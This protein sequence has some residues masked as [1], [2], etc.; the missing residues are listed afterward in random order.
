MRGHV[1]AALG[2]P[3]LLAA[4][5]A[6]AGFPPAS[7]AR[8]LPPSP[9]APTPDDDDEDERPKGP[10]LAPGKE[11][12]LALTLSRGEARDTRAARLVA[13]DVPEGT[14]PSPFLAPGP[15]RAVWEGDLG[16]PF[17]G[18]YTF[19]AAGRGTIRVEINGKV[20]LEGS[21][22]DLGKLEGKAAKLRK[23]ANK[24]VVTYEAPTSG[25]AA[26][27]LSWSCED[28]AREPIGPVS[29]ARDVAIPAL[30][31][32]T[33]LREG[34]ALLADLRCLHC[35]APPGPIEGP[36]RMPELATDAPSLVDVGARLKAD[37]IARW[38]ADP[39]SLRPGATMPKVL[40]GPAAP[41]QARDVAAYLASLGAPAKADAPSPAPEAVTAGGRLF[42]NL[43]C[44]GCHMLP[45][46]DD[47]SSDPKRI[48]LRAVGAKW[49]PS[50]LVAFL[51]QPDRHYAW[52][53]MPN[54]H[55]SADEAGK[56]AAYVA[57]P[58]A[59]DLGEPAGSAAKA[60]PARG[61]ALVASAG[62]VNCHALPA[63]PTTAKGPSFASIGPEGWSRGCLAP[64]DGLDGKAPDFGLGEA[65]ARAL[66]ALAA[67]GLDSLTRDAQPE[68]A[69][70]QVKSLRCIACHKRDGYDDAWTDLKVETD[71]LLVGAPTEERDPD[72]LPYPADQVR[73]SLTWIGEKLK[74]EWASAFIAGKVPYKPRP[75]LRAR[76]P[77][78]AVR[79]DGL[80]R[81]LAL[82]HGFASTSPADAESDPEIVPVAKQLVKN[83]GLNCVSCHNI[84]KVAA[85]GVFEA[86]GVNFRHVKE[87][88][89]PDYYARWVR[90]PIRVEPDTKMP[91]Y[92]NGDASVLPTILGGK[93]D[94]Q[95]NALWNYL[96][97]GDSIEP[98][99]N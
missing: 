34:R 98:P 63:V 3:F 51:Q 9:P 2:L 15:F 20:A 19:A 64:G 76:M 81:G 40:H 75:Y 57:S 96:L 18:E 78:F 88:I 10:R 54:F 5:F 25:D 24:L 74:P 82:E 94:A 65:Q 30:L 14:P 72:G 99:G 83:T 38:V 48:P 17:R 45:D 7:A 4:L 87:R 23:G 6:V 28:F 1:A 44:V 97:Q 86:P 93:A 11:L 26:V 56:L 52:I 91:T 32:G 84:G 58:P 71:K 77:A 39:R 85:V 55:L 35:H 8:A 12:G 61:K 95:I 27:R 36:G 33:K 50:A 41:D 60:D 43:G 92:F 59:Q 67:V 66:Q 46:R 53:K 70:R 89:R 37:W 73:P 80:A 13:L 79:A 22:D 31:E 21:G 68:F 47:I 62:C 49:R 69:E 16:I 42:A 90:A 29:L